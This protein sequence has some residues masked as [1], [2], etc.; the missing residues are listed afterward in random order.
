MERETDDKI[1]LEVEK[2]CPGNHY[3]CKPKDNIQKVT[4]S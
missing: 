4:A 3:L 2:I 1:K